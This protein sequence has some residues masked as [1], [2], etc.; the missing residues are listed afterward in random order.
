VALP[1]AVEAVHAKGRLIGVHLAAVTSLVRF[2]A[3][4]SVAH[5]A[6]GDHPVVKV[7]LVAFAGHYTSA[8]V[9][10][11]RGRPAGNV[12]VVVLEYQGNEL[13][14]TVIAARSPQAFGHSHFGP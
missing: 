9:E 3:L 5:V 10:Q 7:C 6:H 13:L 4:Y 8:T 2:R 11:P 12:A 1:A 14:G